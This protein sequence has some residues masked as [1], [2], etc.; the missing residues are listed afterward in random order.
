MQRIQGYIPEREYKGHTTLMCA[1]LE[2]HT[3][4]VRAL[5]ARGADVNAKDCAGRTALMFAVIN[6]HHDTVNVLLEHGADVN[7]RADDGAT[8]LML[9]ASC[10]E[11][12]IVQ[13][14]LNKGADLNGKFITTG[15]NAVLL[16]AG[17]GY[18][19][20]VEMLKRAMA[21][22]QPNQPR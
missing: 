12:R 15:R 14:L 7:A 2:G 18:T 17:K 9:A 21:R 11:P 13:A 8:A 1:A 19:A 10:G 6:M 20:V 22:E 16:A 3:K 5:L 4:E